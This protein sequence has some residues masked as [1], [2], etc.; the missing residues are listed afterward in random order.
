MKIVAALTISILLASGLFACQ[1]PVFRFALERWPADNF[2]LLV[3]S[4][5]PVDQALGSELENLQ[6]SLEAE[7][8]PINLE[9]EVLDLSTLTEAQRISIPGLEKVGAEPSLILIPPQSWQTEETAWSGAATTENLALLLDSPARQQCADHLL[10]GA[11]TVWIIV[12]SGDAEK[13][14]RAKA[15][16]ASGLAK[17]S[18]LLEIPKGVVRREDLNKEMANIDLDD[19]LRSDIPLSISFVSQTLDRRDPAEAVFL[20]ILVEPETLLT[21]EPLIVP[22]FGRGRTAGPV[23]A[24]GLTIDRIFGACEYLCGACS[25]QVKQGNPGYDLLFK[26]SWDAHLNSTII[27]AESEIVQQALDVVSFSPDPPASESD[28]TGGRPIHPAALGLVVVLLAG[29]AFLVLRK[30]TPAG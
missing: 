12:T 15:L 25:C 10:K 11:S 13:D 18:S 24:T 27:T 3:T 2:R 30:P 28:Q 7:P 4:H 17:A 23:S 22:I 19:V 16:L 8:R 14:S 9:L 20:S 6:K 1:V 5:G 21:G 29:G 26:T